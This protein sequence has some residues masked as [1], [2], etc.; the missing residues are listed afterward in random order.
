MKQKNNKHAEIV[1]CGYGLSD[2][3]ERLNSSL[4]HGKSMSFDRKIYRKV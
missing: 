3:F 1:K 2:D 4:H